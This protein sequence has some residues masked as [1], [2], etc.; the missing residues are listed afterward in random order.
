MIKVVK[1]KETPA[2][3]HFKT[4]YFLFDT[5]TKSYGGSG[6]AFDWKLIKNI[7]NKKKSFLSGGLNAGNIKEA[8]SLKPYCLDI[9]SGV[10]LKPGVKST[11]KLNELFSIINSM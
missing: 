6:K 5:Y 10:E 9:S 1:V 2:T 8:Y 7:L 3:K 4:D 11:E